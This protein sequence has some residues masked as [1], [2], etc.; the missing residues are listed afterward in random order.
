MSCLPPNSDHCA[1]ISC[2]NLSFKFS[3]YNDHIKMFVHF[4]F[5]HQFFWKKQSEISLF[6]NVLYF[7]SHSVSD[8]KF[9]VCSYNNRFYI[10]VAHVGINLDIYPTH[11]HVF[12]THIRQT[13]CVCYGL[14]F[15][16]N[17]TMNVFPTHVISHLNT[18]CH[19]LACCVSNTDF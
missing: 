4:C 15:H 7:T 11:L 10:I 9:G 13:G 14:T 3:V 12:A 2:T 6:K 1:H 19:P 5:F 8:W 18:L 16:H 17:I